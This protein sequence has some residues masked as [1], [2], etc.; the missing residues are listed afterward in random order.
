MKI[1]NIHS[2]IMSVKEAKN[3]QEMHRSKVILEGNTGAN[4]K[5]IAGA[6][7]S[8]SSK[9]GKLYAGVVVQE[10]PAFT[11]KESAVME[12]KAEFPYIPGY[13]SFREGKILLEVFKV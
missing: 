12:A 9:T 10:Y 3:I 7:V 11:E 4:L 1:N 8:Y 2:W 6:D 5:L 13:L